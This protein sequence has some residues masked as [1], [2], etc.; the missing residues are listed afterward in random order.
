ME[1]TAPDD[2]PVRIRRIIY[3]PQN[4]IAFPDLEIK[5]E[6]IR[7]LENPLDDLEIV[8]GNREFWMHCQCLIYEAKDFQFK[9]TLKYNELEATISQKNRGRLEPALFHPEY[10]PL[11]KLLEELHVHQQ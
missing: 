3:D 10:L 7:F 4:G 2:R 8:V 9:A 11:L 1:I 5:A 6:A